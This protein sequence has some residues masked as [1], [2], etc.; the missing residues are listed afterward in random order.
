MD[1]IREKEM[2]SVGSDSPQLVAENVTIQMKSV[3]LRKTNIKAKRFLNIHCNVHTYNPTA[4]IPQSV[5]LQSVVTVA[6]LSQL[7]TGKT[8][9][10]KRFL[11]NEEVIC[12]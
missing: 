8:L 3:K 4:F 11:V 9:K 5:T 6:A 2:K 7:I 10:G 1:Y 12:F